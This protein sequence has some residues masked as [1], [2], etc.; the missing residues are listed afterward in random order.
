MLHLPAR[1]IAEDEN[2]PNKQS[3][4]LLPYLFVRRPYIRIWTL[5]FLSILGADTTIPSIQYRLTDVIIRV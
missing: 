3:D 2:Y 5:P 4:M 1:F